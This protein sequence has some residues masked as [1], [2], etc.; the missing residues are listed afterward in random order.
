MAILWQ[1]NSQIIVFFDNF[2]T[3]AQMCLLKYSK[4]RVRKYRH[5][6]EINFDE[7]ENDIIL[8]LPVTSRV[9]ISKVFTKTTRGVSVG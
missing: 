2:T 4:N 9:T 8:L 6:T 7:E 3:N 5:Q 1:N